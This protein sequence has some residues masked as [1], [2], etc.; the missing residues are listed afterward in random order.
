MFRDPAIERRGYW[1]YVRS[2]VRHGHFRDLMGPIWRNRWAETRQAMATLFAVGSAPTCKVGGFPLDPEKIKRF[3]DNLD[4]RHPWGAGAQ[5]GHLLFFLRHGDG[6]ER[7][8]L[9]GKDAVLNFFGG[10]ESPVT[11]GW[12]RGQVSNQEII[13]GAMK[14]LS[15]LYW[16]DEPARRAEVLAETAAWEPDDA[17]DCAL[18]NRMFVLH[19]LSAQHG[20]VPD[21]AVEI[22]RASLD[23][24]PAFI[25]ADGGFSA[26]KSGSLPYYYYTKVS[27]GRPVGDLHGLAL[28]TWGITLGAHLLGKE[29][30]LGWRLVAP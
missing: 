21:G 7:A 1:R 2:C 15:G 28:F 12:Y 9:A 3:L 16:W 27:D 11:G 17:H 5:A 23:A 10:I 14:V 24:M 20:R 25:Q 30:S 22:V 4:W 18:V 19:R 13:N 6:D 8:R 29:R 26:S